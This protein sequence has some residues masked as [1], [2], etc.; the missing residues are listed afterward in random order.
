MTRRKKSEVQKQPAPLSV[1]IPRDVIATVDKE[2]KK[3]SVSRHFKIIDILKTW[4]SFMLSKR[5]T[6]KLLED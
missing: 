2:A 5:K 3:E 1:R 4:H 6:E